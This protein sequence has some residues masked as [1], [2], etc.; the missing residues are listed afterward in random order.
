MEKLLGLFGYGLKI[1]IR[2]QEP[3][4]FGNR[5]I[6]D[7]TSYLLDI[8]LVLIRTNKLFDKNIDAIA[9]LLLEIWVVFDAV[10][11]EMLSR[12]L[13]LLLANCCNIWLALRDLITLLMFHL[14][15]LTG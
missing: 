7:H 1:L 11:D 12:L 9:N 15:H 6:D 3:L 14:I 5:Q 10:R 8:L 4:L 2:H 13:V